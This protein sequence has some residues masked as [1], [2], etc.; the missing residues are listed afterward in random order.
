MSIRC[1]NREE[2]VSPS[3][4]GRPPSSVF[5]RIRKF[6]AGA[7]AGALAT[8]FLDPAVGRRRRRLARDRGV[9][10]A[11]RGTRR[12][13]GVTRTAA[14]RSYGRARGILQALRPGAP[15][16]LD[17]AELAHKVESV[18]FR[19]PRVPKGAL[20][21]NAESGCVFVR[22]EVEDQV[23][24]DVVMDGVRRIKGVRGVENLM[25]VPGTPARSSQGGALLHRP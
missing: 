18:I 22:G 19:D 5:R 7:A 16:D 3:E 24:I 10:L 6:V 14:K 11:R 25:H 4:T 9:A 20:N 17:D 23:L 13:V 8:Y 12:G 15:H 1:T 2:H 21:I